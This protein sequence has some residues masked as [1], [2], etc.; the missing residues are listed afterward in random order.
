[1]VG[2]E[3]APW[4]WM[5][6]LH[7]L[8]LIF[9]LP[10]VNPMEHDVIKDVLRWSLALWGVVMIMRR[11]AYHAIQVGNGGDLAMLGH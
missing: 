11:E 6:T 8:S 3:V 1:M 4:I 5:P 9:E 2:A 7:I 10:Y